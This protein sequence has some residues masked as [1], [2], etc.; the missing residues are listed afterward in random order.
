MKILII[1]D[2]PKIRQ[3]IID[4]F[5]IK[6][7]TAEGAMNGKVALEML[8]NGYD[9][10]ILDMN[11]PEM[12]GA[13]FIRILRENNFSCPVLVLTSNSM[14]DDKV[15]MFGLGADDYLTK[16]FDMRELEMRILSLGRRKEKILETEIIFGNYKICL[17]KR[18]VLLDGERVDLTSKE[19]AIIEFL[20]RHKGFP[21]TKTDILEA[22]W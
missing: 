1:E 4:F 5:K 10:I 17:Q 20:A 2:H 13:D 11:M 15:E 8:V 22:V 18:M 7:H 21:K 19:Y 3:N 12:G 14:I 6:G 9:I 16:P